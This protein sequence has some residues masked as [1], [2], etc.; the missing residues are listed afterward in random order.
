MLDN[1]GINSLG[2]GS[3]GG[4][5]GVVGVGVVGAVRGIVTAGGETQHE[6]Q[7]QRER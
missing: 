6:G 2:S 1:V 3:G 5:V 4:G 7:N